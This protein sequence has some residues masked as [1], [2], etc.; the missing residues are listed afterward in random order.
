MQWQPGPT[1]I[2]SRRQNRAVAYALYVNAAVLVAILVALLSRS[3]SPSILSA[4]MAQHQAPIA[5]GG[6]VFIM[7]A[8]FSVNTW[9]CYLL[10]IDAQTVVAYQ[11]YPGDKQLRFIAARSYR[12]D[13]RLSNFNTTPP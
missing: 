1:M 8:Q 4:A 11:F 12:Y 10:D 7:P 6:G 5:G 13:R 9:G 2:E 3:D